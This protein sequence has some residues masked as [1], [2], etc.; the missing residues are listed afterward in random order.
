ME[1]SKDYNSLPN[2]LVVDP[3]LIN[4]TD[5]A[6]EINI[7]SNKVDVISDGSNNIAELNLVGK[8]QGDN[9]N[10]GNAK[11]HIGTFKE[12]GGTSNLVGGG[13]CFFSDK[14]QPS[15]PL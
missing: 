1:F 4:I 6:S 2:K 7:I 9:N 11:L 3:S 5:S 14:T 13:I 10:L 15:K 12:I 8:Y